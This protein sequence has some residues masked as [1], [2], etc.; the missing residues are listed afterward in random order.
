MFP[1][2]GA[3]LIGLPRRAAVA[4]KTGAIAS[5][6]LRFRETKVD[7][8]ALLCRS[9]QA[10]GARLAVRILR[11]NM[12]RRR[13]AIGTLNASEHTADRGR[14]RGGGHFLFRVLPTFRNINREA[15]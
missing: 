8:T 1:T 6:F 10:R 7:S 15:Q 5:Q 11:R 9:S 14:V 2:D 3:T 4:A 12:L 13:A